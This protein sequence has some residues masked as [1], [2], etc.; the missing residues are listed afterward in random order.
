MRAAAGIAQL[1]P[2][3][4]AG[5]I[6]VRYLAA[7]SELAAESRANRG[8]AIGFGYKRLDLVAGNDPTPRPTIDF[9]DYKKLFYSIYSFVD[10]PHL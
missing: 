9:F 4:C 8:R 7:N 10:V 1:Y 6:A 2:G 5:R 3:C